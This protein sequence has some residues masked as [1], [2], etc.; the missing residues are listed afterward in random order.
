M[1]KCE[2]KCFFSQKK[3][4][5]LIT[6][7]DHFLGNFFIAE[8]FSIHIYALLWTAENILLLGLSFDWEI[9]SVSYYTA[10]KFDL[11]I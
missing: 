3:K 2:S 5:S 11:N 7:S 9:S 4:K 8:Y 10:K 1:N 6:F